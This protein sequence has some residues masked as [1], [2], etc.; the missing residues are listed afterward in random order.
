M[1]NIT[2]N[3]RNCGRNNKCEIRKSFIKTAEE[4]NIEYN[5]FRL[6]CPFNTNKFN[7]GDKVVFSI[8][9]FRYIRET[10]WECDRDCDY[11]IDHNCYDGIVTFK[12]TAY[13]KYIKIKG[14]VNMQYNNDKV[15]ICV[16][17][18]EWKKIKKDLSREDIIFLENID[19]KFEKHDY[20]TRRDWN[21]YFF[22]VSK[23]KYVKCI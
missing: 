12:N 8:G 20:N 6:K 18:D 10:Q 13:E 3:C 2:I 23:L 16:L 1:Q 9:S 17:L 19:S 15:I 4:F 11:C 7:E 5:K 22:F 14:I 21:D